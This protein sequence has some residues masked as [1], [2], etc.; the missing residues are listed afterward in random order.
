MGRMPWIF[1][2]K[3]VE[4]EHDNGKPTILL[5]EEILHLLIGSFSHYVQKN[6]QVLCHLGGGLKYFLCSPL[7]EEDSHFDYF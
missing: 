5:M 1:G 6:M 7:F 2:T 3:L 4:N